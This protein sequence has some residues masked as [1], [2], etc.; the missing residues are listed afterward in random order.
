MAELISVDEA[1]SLVLK[2]TDVLKP[3]RKRVEDALLS[4]L[5][6]DVKSPYDSP[7][8]SQSSMDGYAIR[9]A[10]LKHN[11]SLLIQGINQA[12]NDSGLEL[13]KGAAIRIFTGA[14]L[15]PGADTIII[16]ENVS[17]KDGA[18]SILDLDTVKKNAFVREQGKQ[19]KKNKVALPGGH[20]LNPGS[21]GYLTSLGVDRVKTISKPRISI[22]SVGNEL[23]VP[24]KNL[25]PAQIYESNSYTLQSLLR[26]M[27]MMAEDIVR[28]EDDPEKLN[29]IFKKALR[30]NDVVIVTGGVSVGD[31]DFVANTLN[32]LQINKVFHG[33]AQKPG[34][35][36]YFGT[37]KGKLIFALPGNPASV[38]V[39][40]YQYIYPAL[41]KMT[42]HKELTL[43]SSDFICNSD[44]VK[45]P[46]LTHF[47]KG[48][49][50]GDTVEILEGQ[51][52][53]MLSSFALANCL[54]KLSSTS[55]GVKAKDKVTV[56]LISSL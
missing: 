30:Q 37:Y 9:F 33:V 42:G 4:I 29:S 39:C 47:L 6:E 1:L 45:K 7:P 20:V 24:G 41:R 43:P 21:I 23:Q 49:T 35:P 54:V 11:K 27:R 31:Y 55:T 53:Y 17:I 32:L 10:D 52:S 5:A 15:P 22:I 50:K 12:G 48:I 16:Q 40:F 2:N 26:E 25:K 38:M 3:E 51:E 36:M 28:V 46:G 8:F 34:K 14:M 19:L 18:I 56:Q 44:Y 13:Q